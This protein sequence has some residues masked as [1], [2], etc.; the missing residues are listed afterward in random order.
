MHQSQYSRTYL[1]LN[2]TGHNHGTYEWTTSKAAGENSANAYYPN[3]EGIDR[4]HQFLYFV[5]KVKR[6]LVIVNLDNGTYRWESVNHRLFSGD[7]GQFEAEPDQVIFSLNEDNLFFTEDGG[8]TPG[9]YV[10]T[11]SG[12][13]NT[14][15]QAYHGMYVHDETVSLAFSPDGRRMYFG[16]QEIGRIFEVTRIDGGSFHHL[17]YGRSLLRGSPSSLSS[18]GTG[19]ETSGPDLV[20]GLKF[21][22][23]PSI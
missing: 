14:L 5:S 18:E 16:I 22:T 2:P 20:M 15:V 10:R 8:R 1:K 23:L 4:R 7:G 12:A 6:R 17:P 9:I 13:Y 19:N 11:P 3:S 21:H